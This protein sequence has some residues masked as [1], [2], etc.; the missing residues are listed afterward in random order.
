MLQFSFLAAVPKAYLVHGWQALNFPGDSGPLVGLLL[1]LGLGMIA[2]LLMFD[3]ILS[4]FGT[5]L[6]YTAATS[7]ILYGMAQ[8]NHLPKVFLKL[9]RHHIPYVTLFANFVVGSLTFLPFPGWQ[10][11]VAFLSSTSILSYGIGPI[12][13]LAMRKLRPDMKRPFKLTGSLMICYFAFYACN[14]MLYWCGFAVIWKLF[15]ALLIGLAITLI[16]QRKSIFACGA[17]LYWFLF[18]I[19]CMLTLSYLGSFGGINAIRF[20]GDVILILPFS[21][22]M[23]YLSQRYIKFEEHSYGMMSVAP[24]S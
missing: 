2:F 17:S 4:P 9:N 24:E 20:P 13:L 7:R 10:K 8:N 6:V 5:T 21:I 11:M 15:V 18:Y 1:L 19:V 23:L 12:C 22:I 14:L 16:Y 3:A